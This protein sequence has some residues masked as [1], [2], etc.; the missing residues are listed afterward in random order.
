MSARGF[1][2]RMFLL[3]L[4]AAAGCLAGCAT[5]DDRDSELPWNMPQTWESAPS[6]PGLEPR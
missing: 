1:L 2:R 5:T 4:G 3:L 6:I